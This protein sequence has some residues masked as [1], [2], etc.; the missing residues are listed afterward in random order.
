[1]WQ[2]ENCTIENEIPTLSVAIKLTEKAVY[3]FVKMAKQQHTAVPSRRLRDLAGVEIS[4][5]RY[6]N[7]ENGVSLNTF[8]PSEFP[9]LSCESYVYKI[10][11]TILKWKAE[12]IWTWR[13]IS[14]S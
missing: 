9:L 1:M 11:F 10:G 2:Y 8:V 7:T 5:F 12:S 13:N 6:A 14:T 4:I 3:L